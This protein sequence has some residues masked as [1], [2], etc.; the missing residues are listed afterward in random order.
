MRQINKAGL[1]FDDHAVRAALALTEWT[2]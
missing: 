2:T 1:G